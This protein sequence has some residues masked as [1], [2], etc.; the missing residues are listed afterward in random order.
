M[1]GAVAALDASLAVCEVVRSRVPVLMDSGVRRGVDVLKALALDAT[2][3]LIGRP[4]LYGPAV[5]GEAGVREVLR[6]LIAD[7]DLQLAFSGCRSVAQVD[8]SLVQRAEW[9]DQPSN[10]VT[11]SRNSSSDCMGASR[12]P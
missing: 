4:Y 2:A 10:R 6:N 3:A 8:R 1:D 11:D 12:L 5:A 9:P 7:L